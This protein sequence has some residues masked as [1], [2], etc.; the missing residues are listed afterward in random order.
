MDGLLFDSGRV[1]LPAH[2][3]M[4]QDMT[5]TSVMACQTFLQQT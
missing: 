5:V 4:M 2:A 3:F 1:C